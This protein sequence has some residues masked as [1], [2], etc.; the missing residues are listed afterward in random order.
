M[1]SPLKS[2]VANSTAWTELSQFMP[3][4]QLSVSDG[5]LLIVFL[6]PEGTFFL[7]R[8]DDPWYR[9]TFLGA[10]YRYEDGIQHKIYLP[11]E[12]ASPMACVQRYQYCD[13]N[14]KCGRLA[15]AIDAM[16]SAL[17]LFHMTLGDVWSGPKSLHMSDGMAR[18][19]MMFQ[20]TVYDDLEDLLSTLGPSSLLS[21]QHLRRSMMGWLPD[22][23]WQ[24]D[25]SNWFAIRMARMQDSF[26]NTARGPIDETVLPF[27][28]RPAGEYQKAMCNSQVSNSSIA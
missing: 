6:S 2:V 4:P 19:F 13:P 8:T 5:D 9:A 27:T 1:G 10:E 28:T 11:E 22:N 17:S 16:T 21:I 18:R 20:A 14:K 25:V 3:I 23:Q 24:L 12:E 7:N 26:V 15:S